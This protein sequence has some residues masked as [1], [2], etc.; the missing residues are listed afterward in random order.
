M[1]DEATRQPEE[2]GAGAKPEAERA[3]GAELP[4]ASTVE[5]VSGQSAEPAPDAPDAPVMEA[6]PEAADAP[7][8]QSTGIG[9]LPAKSPTTN[10]GHHPEPD[11]NVR[12][13]VAHVPSVLKAYPGDEVTF[14]TRVSV[15]DD[16][17]GFTLRLSLPVGVE[18][19]ST[20]APEAAGVMATEVGYMGQF[21]RWDVDELRSAGARYEFET[22]VRVPP[23]PEI[24]ARNGSAPP[25]EIELVTHAAVTP[26]AGP[27]A[28]PLAQSQGETAVVYIRSRG[29]YLKYLPAVFERD[30]FMSRF[31]MLFESFWSPIEAQNANIWDYFDPYLMPVSMLEWLA[32]RLDLVMGDDWPEDAQRRMLASAVQLYRRRGTRRGMQELLELYT[33]GTVV[34]TERRANNLRLGSTARLGQGVALGSRNQPHT[35]GVQVRLPPIDAGRLPPE[36]SVAH[37]RER[38]RERIRALLELEKPAHVTYTLD[39]DDGSS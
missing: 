13:T 39:I 5:P 33:G 21:L 22:K 32:E 19:L 1:S 23:V 36:S 31:V 10:G 3:P 20:Q 18:L 28:L 16:L 27:G 9:T 30:P 6:E 12:V 8:E 2:D 4:P 38:R 37:E 35:F 25:T 24:A 15:L 34:I 14:W 11:P 17:P 7:A 29:A 26:L